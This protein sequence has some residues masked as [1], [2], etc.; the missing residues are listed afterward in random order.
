MPP[1]PLAPCTRQQAPSSHLANQISSHPIC[2]CTPF[3]PLSPTATCMLEFC[4]VRV[5]EPIGMGQGL[6]VLLLHASF[7]V[8][9]HWQ[10]R[11]ARRACLLSIDCSILL[12]T[13]VM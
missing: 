9:C 7:L 6:I 2:W 13:Q 4:T 8:G 1:S 10:L 3:G 11:L 5:E 12:N